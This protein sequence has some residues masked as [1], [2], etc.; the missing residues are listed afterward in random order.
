MAATA[1]IELQSALSTARPGLLV[2]LGER[3]RGWHLD[4]QLARGVPAESDPSLRL[5][6]RRLTGAKSRRRIADALERLLEDDS[7]LAGLSSRV[8]VSESVILAARPELESL[9]AALR[10]DGCEVRGVALARLFIIDGASPLYG[11]GSELELIA[12]AGEAYRALCVEE[13]A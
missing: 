5:R 12:A 4:Q 11:R 3:M 6:A 10:C 8:P 13:P 9:A 1:T 2:R 7:A